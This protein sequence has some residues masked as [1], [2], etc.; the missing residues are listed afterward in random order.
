MATIRL[1]FV[2]SFRDRHGKLRWRFRRKGFESVM[3]PGTPGE[4]AFMRAYETAMA[5]G[6]ITVGAARTI[7]GSVSAL[8]A[9]YYES[10]NF[11]NLKPGTQ[12]HYRGEIE[13]FRALNGDN[14]IAAMKPA[15]VRALMDRRASTPAAANHLLRIVKALARFG[16]ERG[17][18]TASPAQGVRKFRLKG[19]GYHSWTDDELR[20]FEAKHPSGSRARLAFALLIYTAQRRGDVVRMGRQH[21]RDGRLA[22]TQ[23]KTGETVRVPILPQL[24]A[25]LDAAP[26]GNLTFLVTDYGRP[27][28]AAGFGNAFRDWCNEAGLKKCSAHGLRKAAARIM[29]E[30][31]VS[32]FDLMA[33]T[34]HRTLAEAERYTRA[35]DQGKR[36]QRAAAALGDWNKA[37]RESVKP[38]A[39]FDKKSSK[40]LK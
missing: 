34:G 11:K 9:A 19:E 2:S 1:R 12:R 14:P 6:K 32:P 7:P 13:R 38:D 8:I 37:E 35:A 15:N 39:G 36:A 33:I 24:Q 16:L 18:L 27:Y 10:S 17:F 29:A 5:G 31:G 3:L 4:A 28:T 20:Q 21:V 30:A 25:E 40:P 26:R 23:E 22:L